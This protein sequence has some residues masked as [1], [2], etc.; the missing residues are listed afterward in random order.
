MFQGSG[1]VAPPAGR[2]AF[3]F[4]YISVDQ[5]RGPSHRPG[6][7]GATHWVHPV[8]P[9]HWVGKI[10]L[11]VCLLATLTSCWLTT[12][13]LGVSYGSGSSLRAL[14]MCCSQCRITYAFMYVC[15]TN[16]GIYT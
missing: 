12:A 2:V 10:W 3:R 6:K 4:A 9:A 11:P 1:F 7:S 14:Y 5:S 8:G 13:S 16:A 15:S